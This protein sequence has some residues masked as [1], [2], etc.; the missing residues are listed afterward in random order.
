MNTKMRSVL[1]SLGYLLLAGT[2]VAGH[3]G[4]YKENTVIG[5]DTTSGKKST[6]HAGSLDTVE[7]WSNYMKAHDDSDFDAIREANAVGFTASTADGSIIENTDAQIEL[8]KEW[9]ATSNPKWTHQYSIANELT[10]EDG[11]LQQWVTS[12]WELTEKTDG[13]VS[14]RQEIFDVLIENDK[15]KTIYIAARVILD[16]KE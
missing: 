8:L 3:H 12:G 13:V 2:A 6:L 16:P 15:I 10:D 14:R 5:Y 7:I 11:E 4:D 1:I 9:F